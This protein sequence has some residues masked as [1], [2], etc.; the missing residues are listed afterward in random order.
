MADDLAAFR[1][2]NIGEVIRAKETLEAT[3]GALPDAV[4][5]IE[6]G[7][8]VSSANPRATAVI[9]TARGATTRHVD[10]LPLSDAARAAVEACLRGEDVVLPLDLSKA[11]AM[12][13]DGKPRKLLPR[14]VPID[15]HEGMGRGAVLVFSDVTELARLDEMRMELVAVASHE[16]RTPLTTIRMTLLM[17]QERAARLDERDR[18]LV[19]TALL[20][21][22]QLAVT[23]AEF[24]DLTRIEAGQLRLHLDRV[25]VERL[26][27]E[28]IAAAGPRAEE[29]KI[30]LQ[31]S[32]DG[33]CPSALRGDASR[34]GV[35]LSNILRNALKYTPPG[36]AISV[37]ASP[38]HSVDKLASLEIRISDTGRGV[39]EEFRERVFEKF[40]RVEHYRP[41][42]EEGVRG[43][44]I[45]L[46]MA[47]EIIEAH[48]GS[49][50]C[51]E[52]PGECGASF[53]ILLPADRAGTAVNSG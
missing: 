29:A 12:L 15:R 30:S 20:G 7:G 14:I 17:L 39:P 37:R 27:A 21:V 47:R 34:L 40:F 52:G 48:G 24:L 49:V 22:E 9:N 3:L 6:P 53:V 26:I 4:V 43:S 42:S 1:R 10:E 16:L 51:R 35:V 28:A 44:G 19:A 18:E 31:V 38:T 11:V 41:G 25:D 2:A 36:G 45:G 5:V 50:A 46:Y 8:E 32:V 13:I 23:V 33:G